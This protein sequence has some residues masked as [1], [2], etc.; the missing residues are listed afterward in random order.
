MRPRIRL[1]K[2]SGALKMQD[3]ENAGPNVGGGKCR[4]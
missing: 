2:P 4:I 1:E 3:R